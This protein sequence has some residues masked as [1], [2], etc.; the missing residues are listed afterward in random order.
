MNDNNLKK[1]Q[2]KTWLEEGLAAGKTS[3]DLSNE[4][5]VSYKLIE[6]HLL[7]FGIPFTSQKPQVEI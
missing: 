7:E 2:N 6:R 1:H 3:K 5:N 4:V